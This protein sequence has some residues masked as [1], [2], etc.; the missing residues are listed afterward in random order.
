MEDMKMKYSF[1]VWV[2]EHMR[3]IWLSPLRN[4]DSWRDMKP[5]F[6]GDYLEYCKEK[7][8]EPDAA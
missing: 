2:K 4:Y 7:N 8:L 6:W 3:Y 1:E 5:E